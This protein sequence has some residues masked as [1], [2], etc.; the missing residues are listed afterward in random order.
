MTALLAILLLLLPTIAFSQPDSNS[1]VVDT[2][3]F[4]VALSK[5]KQLRWEDLSAS[6]SI[7]YEWDLKLAMSSYY[8]Q[9]AEFGLLHAANSAINCSP[10]AAVEV[11]ERTIKTVEKKF[12]I[13][14]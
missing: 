13:Y 10:E 7:T 12:P 2:A 5:A 8:T 4:A 14:Y 1:N 9:Y 6:L 3:G 11:Y